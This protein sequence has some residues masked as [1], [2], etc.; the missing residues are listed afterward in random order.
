[1]KSTILAGALGITLI[2]GAA[3]AYVI[4]AGWEEIFPGDTTVTANF[5]DYINSIVGT[6]PAY[7][8]W[9]EDLERTIWNIAWTGNGSVTP[10][11]DFNITVALEGVSASTGEFLFENGGHTDE[12]TISGQT[13][14][15]GDSA[16][17]GDFMEVDAWANTH[18]DGMTLTFLDP[19][20]SPSYIGFDLKINYFDG[21]STVNYYDATT[22]YLAGTSLYDLQIAAGDM[23]PDQDFKVAAPVPE[24]ATMLLFGTGLIGLAGITRRKRKK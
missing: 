13:I 6:G 18:V 17:I 1:M 11:Y 10:L 9:T 12:I 21:N 20:Q 19:I 15:K 23:S 8:I 16:V 14:L 2:A 7:Y 5:N 22:S 4:D 24:P 3:N